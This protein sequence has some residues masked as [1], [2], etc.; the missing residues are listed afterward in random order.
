M[1]Y[2]NRL[3]KEKTL[4]YLTYVGYYNIFEIESDKTDI[5]SLKMKYLKDIELEKKYKL[6]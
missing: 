4:T 5:K 6:L 1:Q 2:I 3:L